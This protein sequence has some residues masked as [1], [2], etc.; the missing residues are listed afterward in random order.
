MH[1]CFDYSRCSLL[2][3]FPVYNYDMEQFKIASNDLEAYVKITVKQALGYN[4]QVTSNPSEACVFVALLGEGVGGGLDSVNL[5][6][7]LHSLPYWGGDGRNHILLNLGRTFYS[8][9][10][11]EGINTGRAIIV[12]SH[13]DARAFRPGFD[14]VTPPLLGLPGGDLWKNLPPIVPAK[15][16]YLLSFQ[17]ELPRLRTY[18]ENTQQL[19]PNSPRLREELAVVEE[20]RR[21]EHT[22]T[23]D[24]FFLHFTCRGGGGYGDLEEWRMCDTEGMRT[25]ALR[26]STFSLVLAS[27]SPVEVST[28]TLQARIYEA[29]KYG[30]VPLILGNHVELPLSETIDWRKLALVFPKARV[31]EVHF[32]LRSLSDADLLFMRRQGRM[33]WERFFGSTQVGALSLTLSLSLS[34][35]L[36]C[37][38][39]FPL[40]LSLTLLLSLA[41]LLS[42]S[43]TLFLSLSFSYSHVFSLSTLM[44]LFIVVILL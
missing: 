2:S 20:L 26:E 23:D 25:Q 24:Q 1:N 32:L 30:A 34:L 13:F 10:M 35:W 14:L 31:T 8:K 41:V 44:S 12:Q 42:F 6:E 37:F 27:P 21:L 15:R 43:F 7:S 16:K 36:Y 33:V 39:S 38:L 3:N 22:H 5:E 4:A 9:N 19:P 18:L 29:L 40:F 28:V 17:G 11:F